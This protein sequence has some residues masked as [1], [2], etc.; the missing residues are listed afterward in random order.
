MLSGQ[1]ADAIATPLVGRWS[2]QTYTKWGKRTPWY[3]FGLITITLTFI[4]TFHKNLFISWGWA[5][6]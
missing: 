3:L 6:D 4:P 2:D 5:S 1:I